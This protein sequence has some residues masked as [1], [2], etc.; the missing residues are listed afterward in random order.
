M[1][2]HS[3]AL[4]TILALCIPTL[5]M[6][7]TAA[8]ASSVA[9]RVQFV[10]GFGCHIVQVN[11]DDPHVKV[12]PVLSQRFP[13]GAE[14][15]G[16]ICAREQ[17]AAAV[18]G[19]FFSKTTLLPIGD[20]VIDGRLVHFG[21]MGSALALTPDNNAQFKRI[22]WGRQQDWGAFESV[23]AGGPMLLEDGQVALAPV[24]ERFR[25]RRVLGR[26]SRVAV[27]ITA[28]N[29]L[30]LVASREQMSLWELAKVMRELGCTGAINLD[31][32]TST[33]MYYRGSSK[34]TPG[35]SLVNVLAVFEN[36][37]PQTRTCLYAPVGE[38]ETVSRERIAAAYRNYMQAQTP[39][40][41]GRLD[42][43]LRLLHRAATLDPRNASYQVRLAE[44]LARQGR[45]REASAAWAS[46]GQILLD[47]GMYDRAVDYFQAALAL[48]SD[49]ELARERLPEAYRGM[50]LE[51][52]A[53][54]V[55]YHLA[56]WELQ[57]NFIAARR[58]LMIDLTTYAFAATRLRAPSTVLSP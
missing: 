48:D 45:D 3:S 2:R 23:I 44:T 19:T 12:T 18:T 24:N 22:P 34:V 11:L 54:M 1:L 10:N 43:A 41:Q 28:H 7:Q 14:P 31:G 38:N 30:L 36:V 13:G 46:A 17:P 25:D 39:L 47:K 42:D 33:G 9:Y 58:D 51:A 27:G 53:R 56:L 52:R 55:E 29:K 5:V 20:L 8:D 49:C 40:A 37:S 6:I 32:G 35:R 26:A 16:A 21:G 4:M 15:M 57:R 50:G